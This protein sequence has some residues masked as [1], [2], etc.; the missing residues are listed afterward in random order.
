MPN[1]WVAPYINGG[2]GNRLFQVA[3][4][5]GAE[6]KWGLQCVFFMKTFKTND[7]DNSDTITKLFPYIFQVKEATSYYI[8]PEPKGHAF[9]YTPL[10]QSAPT[11]RVV[12]EGCRLTEK[13]FP[14]GR[15][16]SPIWENVLKIPEQEKLLNL[17]KL[18]S[19]QEKFSTWFLHIR[20]GDYKMLPHHQ[21]P[22]VV[23][24][25][26]CL[27]KIPKGS[28]VLLFSDEPELCSQWVFQETRKRELD[29]DI[30]HE[31]K[32]YKALWIM[33]QCLGGA[34]VSNSTFSWWGA[35]FARQ[36]SLSV[37]PYTAYYPDV[38]G[39]GLPP[40]KDVVP[41]WGTTIHVVLPS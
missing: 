25:L 2:L 31:K 13:Y 18:E 35:Y 12:L 8:H 20:L 15:A 37:K 4:A 21:I 36:N 3:A 16:I 40:A 26:E 19:S 11:D 7:H 5:L 34:V 6:E 28:R 38:W 17:Y 22:I 24:M 32:D 1:N 30:C 10:P 29:F 23:Y 39:Q 41:S 9:T 14:L 33:S 27:N